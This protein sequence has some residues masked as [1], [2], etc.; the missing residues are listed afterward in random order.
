MSKLRVYSN[1]FVSCLYNNGID[2]NKTITGKFPT[3]CDDLFVPFLKGYI[4]GDGCIYQMKNNLVVNIT[5]CTNGVLEYVNNMANRLLHINGRIYSENDK[6]Y[7]II[8]FRPL[9]VKILLDAI[10]SEDTPELK[11]KRSIYD[12][13]YGF[14]TQ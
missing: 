6:K 9:D 1:E 7:R 11:R 13:F 4:D 12:N 3:I 8:W 2:F 10:Y 5:S 14:S